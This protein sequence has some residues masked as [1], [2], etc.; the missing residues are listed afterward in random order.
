[1]CLSGLKQVP[2]GGGAWAIWQT[3]VAP[4]SMGG[5]PPKASLNGE[6][7]EMKQ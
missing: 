1:M 7:S 6:Y 3:G 4:F 5:I 2:R